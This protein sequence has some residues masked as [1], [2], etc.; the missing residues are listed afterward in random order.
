MTVVLVPLAAAFGGVTLSLLGS[1]IAA[2]DTG[3][4]LAPYVGGVGNGI[5]VIGLVFVLRAVLSGNLVARP[6]AEVEAKLLQLA[7]RGIEREETFADIA[8]RLGFGSLAKK[9]GR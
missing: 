3:T 9:H 2:A 1:I 6:V 5:A 4:D 7:E 8:G